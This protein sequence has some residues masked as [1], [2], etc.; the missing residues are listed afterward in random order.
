MMKTTG[1]RLKELRGDN[2]M[3]FM[4]EICGTN[5]QSIR[6]WETGRYEIQPKAAK[7]LADHFQISLDWLYLGKGD[8][9]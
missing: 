6:N 5:R 8:T 4:A 2:S 1:Q 3:Q 9:P 7:I